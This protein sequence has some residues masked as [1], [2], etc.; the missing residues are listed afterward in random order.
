ME[1][2]SDFLLYL[3]HNKYSRIMKRILLLSLALLTFAGCS[4]SKDE[5]PPPPTKDY[6]ISP[7]LPCGGLYWGMPESEVTDIMEENEFEFL[8][9][10]ELHYYLCFKKPDVNEIWILQVSDDRALLDFEY[11]FISSDWPEINAKKAYL[12][13]LF[14]FVHHSSVTAYIKYTGG[15][16]YV[17]AAMYARNNSYPWGV[18]EYTTYLTVYI[19][20][21]Q[22]RE[23][24]SPL[25]LN[26]FVKAVN[27]PLANDE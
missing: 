18:Y 24:S 17:D 8:G 16:Q 23:L 1:L 22:Q 21:Q 19:S 9:Y 6:V 4:S 13:T 7:L 3:P 26:S 20:K 25:S 11:V 2:R 10:D 5:V 15:T 12:T 14:G 27:S